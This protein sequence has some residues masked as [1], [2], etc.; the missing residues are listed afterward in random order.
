MP[1]AL[2]VDDDANVRRLVCQVL[3]R[4]GYDVFE[5]EDGVDAYA[6]IG[7]LNG[8][9]DVVII[10]I[11]MPRM[12]GRE[13]VQ[14]VEAEQRDLKILCISG[15]ADPMSP[16][17]RYFLAKPF[18][19]TALLAM[20]E[21]VLAV[22]HPPAASKGGERRLTQSDLHVRLVAAEA[23]LEGADEEYRRLLAV[24]HDAGQSPRDSRL[25]LENAIA[26]KKTAFSEYNR[27][28]QEW[29]SFQAEV[30]D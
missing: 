16:P 14:R 4:A 28:F 22:P 3:G 27:A 30:K 17:G 29:A 26:L 1:T 15:Y 18:T 21:K 6:R 5:A 2:V 13:L 11:V 24:A 12:S 25:A 23:K 7:E 20:V 8:A 10:D 19:P 9:L